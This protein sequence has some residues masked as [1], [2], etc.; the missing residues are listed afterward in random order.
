MFHAN[1]AIVSRAK[2]RPERSAKG[3]RAL[4]ASASANAG[5]SLSCDAARRLEREW[6]GDTSARRS[7]GANVERAMSASAGGNTRCSRTR[8]ARRRLDC[9]SRRIIVAR[10]GISA[11]GLE[12]R[13]E[14]FHKKPV[15]VLLFAPFAPT[16]ASVKELSGASFTTRN[17]SSPLML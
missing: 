7:E 6:S 15:M 3:A 2:K 10:R 13:R 14:H 11:N 4:S 12:I 17:T 9:H 5:C 16:A 8:A 1:E